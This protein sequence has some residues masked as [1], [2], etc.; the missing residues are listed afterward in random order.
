MNSILMFLKFVYKYRNWIPKLKKVE[1]QK[2][3]NI[4][5]LFCSMYYEIELSP[6]LCLAAQQHANWM[7]S[8]VRLSHIGDKG[9]T[10]GFRIR[11]SKYI[12]DS[13]VAEYLSHSTE[14]NEDVIKSIIERIKKLDGDVKFRYF[15]YGTN[16]HYWCFLLG[17]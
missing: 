6:E 1:T 5:D 2:P 11:E 13:Y 10:H 17:K 16:N 14:R 8:N 3:D 4:L 7:G 12:S 9:K 15:G